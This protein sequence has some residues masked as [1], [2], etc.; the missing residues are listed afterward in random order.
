MFIFRGVDCHFWVIHGDWYFHM[1]P[2]V[3]YSP[4]KLTTGTWNFTSKYE[5]WKKTSSKP[6][7][8]L[9]LQPLVS[10]FDCCVSK[11][12]HFGWRGS[13]PSLQTSFRKISRVSFTKFPGFTGASPGAYT[14]QWE[15]GTPIKEANLGKLKTLR[16]GKRGGWWR[17]GG[18]VSNSGRKHCIPKTCNLWM[19]GNEIYPLFFVGMKSFDLGWG[20]VLMV[21]CTEST[22]K[23]IVFLLKMNRLSKGF[24]LKNALRIQ[25]VEYPPWN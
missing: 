20:D 2:Y 23:R 22:R 7:K 24:P 17:G 3:S 11:R 6:P 12:P 21:H 4:Q 8:F 14:S 25:V 9:A 16:F 13:S 5:V 10:E 18:L 15:V 19:M 1:Y